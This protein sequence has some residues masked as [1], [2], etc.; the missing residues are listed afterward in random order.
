MSRSLFVE[1]FC[2][3]E[4][5]SKIKKEKTIIFIFMLFF[6]TLINDQPND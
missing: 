6:F 2:L 3:V 5:S 4:V 1:K